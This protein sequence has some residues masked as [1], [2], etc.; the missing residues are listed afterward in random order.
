MQGG[1]HST[2][3]LSAGSVQMMGSINT[4]PE[5]PPSE[6]PEPVDDPID[7]TSPPVV[8]R[9]SQAAISLV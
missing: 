3:T 1:K 8:E 2:V 9:T 4:T 5:P 7:P 6:P